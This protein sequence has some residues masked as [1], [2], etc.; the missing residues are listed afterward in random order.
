MVRVLVPPSWTLLGRLAGLEPSCVNVQAIGDSVHARTALFGPG[1]IVT[2]RRER[3]IKSCKR[4]E[5]GG[6]GGGEYRV[7]DY[8]YI[9]L[10]RGV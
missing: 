9:H 7:M 5:W 6:G 3:A 1:N 8:S 10:G 4:M 2:G